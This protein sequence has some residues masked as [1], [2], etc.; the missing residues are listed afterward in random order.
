MCV[1]R[2]NMNEMKQV[3]PGGHT[4]ASSLPPNKFITWTEGMALKT[5][6]REWEDASISIINIPIYIYI[7]IYIY[8]YS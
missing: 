7:N 6:R 1:P 8:I 5:Q 3:I 4:R 2:V